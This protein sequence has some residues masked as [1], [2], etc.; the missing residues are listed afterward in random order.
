MDKCGIEGM[1]D[2]VTEATGTC[3]NNWVRGVVDSEKT[4]EKNLNKGILEEY[5]IILVWSEGFTFSPIRST[6]SVASPW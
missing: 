1:G 6:K 2:A 3:N 4:R 5:N